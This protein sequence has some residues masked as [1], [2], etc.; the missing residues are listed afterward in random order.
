M[1]RG[2][3]RNDVQTGEGEMAISGSQIAGG[4]KLGPLASRNVPVAGIRA[5]TKEGERIS[6]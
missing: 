1:T 2:Q 4:N 5:S 6:T 3:G